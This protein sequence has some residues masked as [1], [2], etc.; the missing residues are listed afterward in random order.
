M[1]HIAVKQKMSMSSFIE[2]LRSH[3]DDYQTWLPEVALYTVV[4]FVCGFLCKNFGR[5]ILMTLLISAAT[6]FVL[7][8]V[9]IVDAPFQQLAELVG[10]Q[11]V[12]SV[13]EIVMAKM[14]WVQHHPLTTI[15]AVIGF[16]LGWKI[17]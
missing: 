11:G 8:Q 3:I 12:S 15:G 4:S 14:M 5:F 13:Q 2:T 7:Q 9:G 17:G 6:I 10:I 16:L 1:E